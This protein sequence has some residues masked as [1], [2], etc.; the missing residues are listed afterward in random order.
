LDGLGLSD[1][2]KQRL[3]RALGTAPESDEFVSRVE[4]LSNEAI[5]EVVDWILARTRFELERHR[6]P[7][8]FGKIRR[9]A[10]T[11]RIAQ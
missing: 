3:A 4:A 5:R 7:Q 6:I 9:E 8:I 10:P 11:R 2:E 1:A